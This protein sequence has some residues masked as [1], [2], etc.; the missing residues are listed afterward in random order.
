LKEDNSFKSIQSEVGKLKTTAEEPLTAE[1][2]KPSL[3]GRLQTPTL[4]PASRLPNLPA[5][6]IVSNHVNTKPATRTMPTNPGHAQI[7][8][9]LSSQNHQLRKPRVGAEVG[10]TV[11]IRYADSG[12]VFEFTI[13]TNA[14]NPDKAI[15]HAG[16]P[17]AKAVL[18]SEIEDEIEVLVGGR[19][20]GATLKKITKGSAIKL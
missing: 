15:V 16:A 8:L 17:L 13:S 9:P 4:A 7:P 1:G 5:R 2:L 6:T 10:D 14:S 11:R 19:V 3:N 20:R 12:E 18:G